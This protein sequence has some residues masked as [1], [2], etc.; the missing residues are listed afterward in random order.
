MRTNDMLRIG[1]PS[2]LEPFIMSCGL[3]NF[4]VREDC[5]KPGEK[6]DK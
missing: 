4:N 1:L 2:A 3:V 5:E 6:V